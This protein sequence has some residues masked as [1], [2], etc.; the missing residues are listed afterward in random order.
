MEDEQKKL[1][2]KLAR[3][4]AIGL[5]M[6][7]SVAIGVAIGYFLDRYLNTGPWLTLIF[8][9]LGIAAGFRSLFSLVKSLDKEGRNK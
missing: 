5:E 8:L 2:K 6:G 1:Y 3:Y 7:F 9:I 4:S